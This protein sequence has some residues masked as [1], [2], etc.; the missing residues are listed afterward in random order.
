MP[1]TMR[2]P[3]SVSSVESMATVISE[4]RPIIA[5]PWP[6]DDANDGW[7]RLQDRT[8]RGWWRVAVISRRGAIRL[9]HLGARIRAECRT[10]SEFGQEEVYYIK[11][12]SKD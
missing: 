10:E 11:F 6:N 8:L 5:I 1:V 9:N 7:R 3:I 12:L 2:T 4:P